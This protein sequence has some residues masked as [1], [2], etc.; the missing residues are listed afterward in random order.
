MVFNLMSD[1]MKKR[2]SWIDVVKGILILIVCLVHVDGNARDYVGTHQF[3]FV[4]DYA[5][6]YVSWY[7]PAFFVVTGF[8]SNF[9][10][11]VRE[12]VLKNIKALILPCIF[13]GVF[14]TSWLNAF[15]SNDGLSYNNFLDLDYYAI[16][17]YCGPWFLPAL[18]IGKM[19]V[20]FLLK[21]VRR[22]VVYIFLLLFLLMFISTILYNRRLLP[23]IWYFQHAL[24]LAPFL[25]A[26]FLLRNKQLGNHQFK[27]LAGGLF[28]EA[29]LVIMKVF[30]LPY[31]YIGGIP[32]MFWGNFWLCFIIGFVCTVSLF[33]VCQKIGRC[34]WLEFLGRHTLTIY[35]LQNCIVIILIK[36]YM[37]WPVLMPKSLVVVCVVLAAAFICAWIDVF[38][39][40]HLPFL[41]G[42]F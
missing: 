20:Y 4:G 2:Q 6:L 12:F 22:S 28:L 34:R 37:Q 24:M 7:M 39:D 15:L 21:Y 33:I 19:L 23:N 14:L 41:K 27:I 36:A 30:H 1:R 40:K 29:L 3:D 32:G 17:L 8:C 16:L 42:K 5:F 10:L 35:L 13:I 38:F 31:P 11:P 18:F 25:F 9:S 26:G